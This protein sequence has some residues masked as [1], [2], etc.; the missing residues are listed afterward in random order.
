MPQHID[1]DEREVAKPETGQPPNPS[2]ATSG[3]ILTVT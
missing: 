3:D 2:G 1:P